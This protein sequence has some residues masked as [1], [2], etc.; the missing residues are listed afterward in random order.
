M[1]AACSRQRLLNTPASGAGALRGLAVGNPPGFQTDR[2]FNLGEIKV[3][4]ERIPSQWIEAWQADWEGRS[5]ATRAEGEA[6]LLR[7]D[8]AQAQAQAE[9]VITL[10]QALQSVV[11]TGKGEIEPYIL[12]TRFVQALRWLSYDPY[13]RACMPPEAMRTLKRLQ[14]SLNLEELGP[15]SGEATS[16]SKGGT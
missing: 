1:R 8:V 12:A 3:E 13:T 6:E 10:I 9:M 15:P 5:L 11:T 14:E 7:M 2:A 16:S 4:D